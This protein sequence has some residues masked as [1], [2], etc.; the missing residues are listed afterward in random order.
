MMSTRQTQ[1]V[2]RVRMK[3]NSNNNSNNKKKNHRKEPMGRETVSSEATKANTSKSTD[4][5]GDKG[6]S[7]TNNVRF[8]KV[9]EESQSLVKKIYL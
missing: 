1:K 4:V 9:N 5:E 7:T 8:K 6:F 3:H 2:R